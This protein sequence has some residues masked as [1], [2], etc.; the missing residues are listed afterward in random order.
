[1]FASRG[2]KLTAL[3]ASLVMVFS[4]VAVDTAEAR[5]G[6]SFGSRGINTQRVIP[7]TPTS[8]KA[9]APVERTM[10][11]STTR[12]NGVAST[13]ARP[14]L[15]G[16]FGGA[17]L[18][19]LLFSGLFGMLF[20]YGF[21]GF[22]GMLALL[23]QLVVV[24]LIISWF[25]RRRQPATAG[26]APLN[27]YQMGSGPSA[28]ASSGAGPRSSASRRAGGRDQVGITDSDL[29]LFETRL[30]E[31][32]DAYS[33][34]DYAALRRITTPEVMGYL[35]EELGANASRGVRNEVFDVKLLEGDVAESWREGNRAFA[36]VAM[37]YESRDITRN[38]AT[39]EIVAGDDRVTPMTE[40]WTFVRD[41]NG[42]WLVS[43]IQE[44]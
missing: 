43:A 19:G 21:G 1:M 10:T 42:P 5:R 31:L 26:G 22:G 30:G 32:Q 35:A 18:G 12:N 17:L 15:F 14:S 33:R 20:G 38:R 8:P 44:A 27:S 9:T 39:G 37:R 3:L 7:A 28:G 4:M 29:S 6:G 34:E 41:G 2:F 40:I 23:V 16:G 24:G 36:T 13:P 25:V 11:N